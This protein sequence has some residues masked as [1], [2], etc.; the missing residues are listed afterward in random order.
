ML[1]VHS[2]IHEVAKTVSALRDRG[3]KNPAVQI[4]VRGPA[5]FKSTL[6]DEIEAEIIAEKAGVVIHGSYLDA[7]WTGKP[8]PIHYVRDELK[9]AA[10]L[11]ATGV[12]VHLA[13]GAALPALKSVTKNL[14]LPR[15]TTLWLE[16]NAVK[17]GPNSFETPEKIL[18]MLAWARHAETEYVQIGLCIDTA[19][20]WSCGVDLGSYEY[21]DHW[22]RGL[23]RLDHP[24][25][26]HLNDSASEFGTGA[27]RH[28]CLTRG[29]LYGR[30]A[31]DHAAA[32][33]VRVLEYAEDHDCMI[34]L[35]RG[36]DD[37]LKDVDLIMGL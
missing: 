14:K 23:G 1:G 36:V 9:T 6:T 31:S 20:L 17:S 18:A 21:A 29:N 35:E 19:H 27:D 33:F 12:V 16:I 34:I 28:A 10:R 2:P 13:R 3:V 4:F 25:M 24:V 11:G 22:L 15:V 26:F 8:G 37:A 5:S 30:F 32:G 7:I